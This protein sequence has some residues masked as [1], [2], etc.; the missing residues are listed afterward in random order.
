MCQTVSASAFRT[1]VRL[2]GSSSIINLGYM[3][4]KFQI[5]D[6]MSWFIQPNEL[7]HFLGITSLPDG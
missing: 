3:L 1:L 2:V 5:F 6:E 4:L 7:I